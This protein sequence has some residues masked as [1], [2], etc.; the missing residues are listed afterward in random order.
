MPS[1]VEFICNIHQQV[2]NFIVVV[3]FILCSEEATQHRKRGRVLSSLRNWHMGLARP[4]GCVRAMR[5]LGHLV[6]VVARH[7]SVI[8]SIAHCSNLCALSLNKVMQ[9][10]IAVD[11]NVSGG[12]HHR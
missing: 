5:F 6:M 1:S 7:L 4:L 11:L 3:V 10:D 12:F 8:T 2:V 9:C